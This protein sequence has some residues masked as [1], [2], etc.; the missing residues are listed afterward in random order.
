MFYPSRQ[1]VLK[2]VKNSETKKQK[3]TKSKNQQTMEL[4]SD[5]NT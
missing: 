1:V 5:R 4:I 3:Q 2:Q